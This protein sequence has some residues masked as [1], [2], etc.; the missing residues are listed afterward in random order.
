MK[1]LLPPLKVVVAGPVGAGKSTFVRAISET[2]VVS[3]EEHATE[4]INK[5]TTT[6]ALD[7]GTIVFENQPIHIFGTPGQDRFQFMWEILCQGAMGLVF[8]VAG[9]KP[10]DF[11]SARHILE[12]ITSRFPIPFIIGVTRQ[13]SRRTWAPDEVAEFFQVPARFALG[14]DARVDKDCHK[15]LYHLFELLNRKGQENEDSLPA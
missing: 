6:V 11:Q 8:L 2:P 12:F 13:D 1:S 15:A 5:V 7:F 9:D 14:V 10:K 3:S 4:P